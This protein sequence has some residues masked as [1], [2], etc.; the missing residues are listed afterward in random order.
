MPHP[1]PVRNLPLES[2]QLRV[3]PELPAVFVER[4]GEL[5]DAM[6]GDV[7]QPGPGLPVEGL[8]RGLGVFRVGGAVLL[9]DGSKLLRCFVQPILQLF[10]RVAL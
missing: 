10:Q 3:V 8:R 9:F 6:V 1:F 2:A 5:D 7:V 4:L